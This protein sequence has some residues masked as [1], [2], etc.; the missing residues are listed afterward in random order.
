MQAPPIIADNS[1]L[2]IKSLHFESRGQLAYYI[3]GMPGAASAR[4]ELNRASTP[5]EL[6]AILTR[7]ALE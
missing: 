1:F 2:L 6:E 4:D 3:K 7:L 5:D